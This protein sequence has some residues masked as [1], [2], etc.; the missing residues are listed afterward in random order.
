MI[1]SLYVLFVLLC[2]TSVE[3]A[4]QVT[5]SV[6]RQ[7]TI[8]D[9]TFRTGDLDDSDAIPVNGVCTASFRQAGSDTVSLYAVSTQAT[10][11]TSGTLLN[12]FSAS[13]TSPFVF[14]P[15]TL[16]VK[17][18]PTIATAGG[19]ELRIDCA[20]STTRGGT[21]VNTPVIPPVEPPVEPPAAPWTVCSTLPTPSVTPISVTNAQDL[22]EVVVANCATGCVLD[23]AG[24][25][26]TDTNVTIGPLSDPVIKADSL[27]SVSGEIVIRAA[28]PADKP[29][30][31]SE[32]GNPAAVF[33]LVNVTTMFRLENLILWGAR[34][35]QTDAVVTECIDT[36]PADG[37]CDTPTTNQSQTWSMGFATKMTTAGDT[38][39]C[40]LNVEVEAT[41]G[42]GIFIR[43]AVASTVENPIVRLSGCGA[44]TCPNLT[45]PKDQAVNSILTNGRGVNFVDS[46]LVAVIGGDIRW[47]NKMGAQCYGSTRCYIVDNTISDIGVSGIT[48]LGSSGEVRDNTL[49]AIGNHVQPNTRADSFGHA[50][51]FVDDTAYTG[52]LDVLIDGNAISSTTGDGI[53]L[54]LRKVPA[55]ESSIVTVSNNTITGTCTN[56]TK[57]PQAAM[58]LGDNS[59]KF[60]AVIA[61]DNVIGTSSCTSAILAQNLI[62]Y[63]ASANTVVNSTSSDAMTYDTVEALSDD[64]LSVNKDINIDA[65]SVGTLTNCTLNGT[66]SVNDS[67]GGNVVRTGCG[68]VSSTND[69]TFSFALPCIFP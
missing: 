23:L 40:L 25:I 44:G 36:T 48:M 37:I 1:R 3:A 53:I 11:A 64:G 22:H 15:G 52:D 69:C 27:T 51:S 14:R 24:G 49:S 28:N 18:K 41:V 62:S 16:L 43:D 5:I 58:L 20:R 29:L 45:T 66:A 35:D 30:L 32:T 7:T 34:Y 6:P 26:Y 13:T 68:D 12:T 42:D 60:E 57:T 55:A 17:T 8:N 46:D 9:F 39:S 31:I 59:D 50:I 21:P 63:T 56:T 4:P 47:A 61:T 38:R 65:A 2:A 67:S 10:P 33:Y 19:S 54:G